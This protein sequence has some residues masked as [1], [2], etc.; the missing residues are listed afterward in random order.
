MWEKIIETKQVN[1]QKQTL[2]NSK[3]NDQMPIGEIFLRMPNMHSV[4][5]GKPPTLTTWALKQAI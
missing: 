2:V 4:L 5:V 3:T 1:G